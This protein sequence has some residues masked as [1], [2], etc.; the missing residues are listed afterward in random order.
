MVEEPRTDE[1]VKPDMEAVLSRT[2]VTHDLHGF[3][4]PVFEAIS[5]AM[6][7]IEAR[8]ADE[9][10]DKGIVKIRFDFANNP[11]KLLISITDN[12]I[13]LND[14]N[15]KSFKTPFSGYKL[16][17][18]GRGFGRFIAFKI[19]ERIN[20]QTRYNFLGKNDIRTFRFNIRDRRELIFFDGTPDF[21]DIGLCIEY[22][23][24]LTN[25]H[26]L[27]SSLRQ[28]DVTDAVGN[29][30]LPYF[31]YKWLPKIT[32]QF[33][34]SEPHNITEYFRAIFQ[35]YS[36]GT[37]ECEIEGR[38]EIL[39]YSLTRVMKS[40]KF[41]SHCLLLSAADRIVGFPRDLSNKIG[42]QHFTNDKNEKYIVI[43]V[44]RGDAFETRL[45]DART[46]A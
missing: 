39:T 41:P 29:H 12:G 9:A 46:R 33:D 10:K 11:R 20:Y 2:H 16:D 43:A 40:K 5:N 1:L 6:H 38:S 21:E 23:N 22:D 17:K 44:V 7:A 34:D 42:E 37:F 25:W 31:L 14:E 35:E 4:L 8:F 36:K 3:L 13:G 45:N 15:Y 32:I 24:L 27:V 26:E 18:R 28:T 19:F 30:F